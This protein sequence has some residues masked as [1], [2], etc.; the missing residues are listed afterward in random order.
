MKK[1]KAKIAPKEIY[2][3]KKLTLKENATSP[4]KLFRD[5]A[6]VPALANREY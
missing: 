3:V 2:L 5:E 6:L 4:P 1:R